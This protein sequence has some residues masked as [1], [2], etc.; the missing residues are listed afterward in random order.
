LDGCS[1]TYEDGWGS[2][3]DAEGPTYSDYLTAGELVLINTF[4]DVNPDDPNDDNWEYSEGSN[5]YS[6]INGTEKNALDAGRYPDTED[7]DRTG[8]LDRTNDYFTKSFQLV[9]TTYFAGETKQNGIPTGWRLY[10]VPLSE[11]NQSDESQQREWNNINH[12]RLTVSD[13]DK[14][15]IIQIAKSNWLATNG[16]NLASP[17]TVQKNSVKKKLI[18]F[19]QFRLSI[20]MIMQTIAHRKVS[21]ENL[22]V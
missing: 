6:S 14:S 12:M 17:Q 9:D 3:L 7:L 18:Q 13:V 19:L 20:Q 21:R 16:R 2:C 1:D 10:R 22:I 5:D 15:T 8:F 11:F 4:S